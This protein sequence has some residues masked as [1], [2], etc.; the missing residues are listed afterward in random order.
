MGL[1][2]AYLPLGAGLVMFTVPTLVGLAGWRGLW[3]INAAA[4]V[5]Y[6]LALFKI[7]P[8]DR[9]DRSDDGPGGSSWGATI[10]HI[11]SDVIKTAKSGGP[12]ILG[13]TFAF[14]PC[15]GSL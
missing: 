3:Q 11:W 10:G 6:G 15:S 5:V 9:I 4:L 1:W 12:L 14:T 13:F 2:A 7:L 8:H